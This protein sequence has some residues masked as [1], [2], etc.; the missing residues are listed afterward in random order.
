MLKYGDG[1]KKIWVTEFGWASVDGL[2][3]G[4]APNYE[5][6]ADNTAQEQAEWT[7]RAYQMARSWGW[8]GVMF[9]WNL[10]FA[11]V[12]GPQDEK[13]AWSIVDQTWNPRPVYYALKN[14][15]K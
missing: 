10:N 5:Y 6:A 14:M 15:Q 3:V 8:V 11:P 7:V 2:G 9:L 4:P 13:A 12:T 1:A